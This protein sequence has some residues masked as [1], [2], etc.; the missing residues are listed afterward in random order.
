MAEELEIRQCSRR[1]CVTNIDSKCASVLCDNFICVKCYEERVL[2]KYKLCA[3]PCQNGRQL[4]AC[5]KKCYQNATKDISGEGRRAWDTD[6]PTKE[7]AQSSEAML[8][9]WLLVHGN[10]NKW[11]GNSSGVSKR[12]IQKE[13]A[14]LLNKKGTEMGIQRSRT[15]DQVGSKISWLEQ[16]YRETKQWVENTG[17]GIREEMG[18]ESFQEK[19]E[20]EKFKHFFV[21]QPIMAE[22]ACMGAV[23]VTDQYGS[24]E[25]EVDQSDEELE[26]EVEM[27]THPVPEIAF[28]NTLTAALDTLDTVDGAEDNKNVEQ[29][30][31]TEEIGV[32]RSA[33][34]S[35]AASVQASVAASRVPTS[36]AQ[37]K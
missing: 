11:K 35:V 8:I 7:Y 18:E 1:G 2:K 19:V 12:E 26:V 6:T 4:V 29:E 10:Y 3:L 27:L 36:A 34:T 37:R 28:A 17:Q 31:N 16:K 23:A 33:A 20:K 14:E 21:L 25:A 5:T 9:D 32:K 22:R 13:I 24:L 15:S 30:G